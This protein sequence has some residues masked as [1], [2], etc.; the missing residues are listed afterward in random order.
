M[1]RLAAPVLS[2]ACFALTASAAAAH[3]T[4][5]SPA[6]RHV[7][8]KQGPCGVGADDARGPNVTT[9]KG[10]ETIVVRWI[11]TIDHPGHYRIS[12]DPNG[13][14]DFVD[15][16]AYDDYYTNEAVLVDAIPDQAGS[17]VMYEQE[18]TLPLMSCDNCTLQLIQMMTDKPPYEIGTNDLYYQ[19]ADLVLE[20]EAETTGEETTGGTTGEATN[21][22]P[23]AGESP[24]TNDTMDEPVTTGGD[25]EPGTGSGGGTTADSGNSDSSEGA[26]SQ[27][28][29]TSG[30]REESGCGCR[31]EGPG[32]AGLAALM[33]L[34][35]ARRR[36]RG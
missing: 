25:E 13:H 7:Q 27:P 23:T 31:S 26:A 6:P 28:G 29:D 32:G 12:F 14:D 24:T 15:P 11:E 22:E 17:Q 9:F 18:V 3:I 8:Q 10:G 21:G 16:A 35:F 1:P 5:V 34:L 19:C 33:T 36:R 2:F 20:G 4:L 30:D